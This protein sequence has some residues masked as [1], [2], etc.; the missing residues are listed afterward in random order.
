MLGILCEVEFSVN[1]ILFSLKLLKKVNNIYVSFFASY[2]TRTFLNQ[3]HIF[4]Y[5]SQK[6]QPNKVYLFSFLVHSAS[7]FGKAS[8]LAFNSLWQN[9]FRRSSNAYI[10]VFK[11]NHFATKFC[12]FPV[13]LIKHLLFINMSKIT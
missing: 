9:N 13:K 2:D 3:V 4:P 7:Y 12:I 6:L 10:H 1:D 11:F 5:S 8:L